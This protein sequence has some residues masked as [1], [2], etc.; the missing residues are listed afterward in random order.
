M[1]EAESSVSAQPISRV[2]MALLLLL[3]CTGDSDNNDRMRS[4]FVFLGSYGSLASVDNWMD[5]NVWTEGLSV[6]GNITSFPL[7]S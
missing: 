1:M 4:S 2:R 6:I 5:N 3:S 7:T